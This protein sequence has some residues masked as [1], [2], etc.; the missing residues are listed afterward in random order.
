MSKTRNKRRAKKFR[1]SREL[2]LKKKAT[3]RQL[4][5]G[6][7]DSIVRVDPDQIP[8]AQP[9]PVAMNFSTY[10]DDVEAVTAQPVDISAE[11]QVTTMNKSMALIIQN[12]S[13]YRN[14]SIKN[15]DKHLVD[16]VLEKHYPYP[17][18]GKEDKKG[19]N[20][21]HIA[22]YYGDLENVKNEINNVDKDKTATG[23]LFEGKT[24]L[25]IA[26]DMMNGGKVDRGPYEEIVNFLRSPPPP[27]T[28]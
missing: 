20:A 17:T 8:I 7:V 16:R 2:Q 4:K 11:K 27:Y 22:A 21:L 25:H 3:R 15:D 9:Y 26:Q 6:G 10:G 19:M 24:A 5:G 14:D 13:P 1:K 28:D 18:L 12:S 23:G